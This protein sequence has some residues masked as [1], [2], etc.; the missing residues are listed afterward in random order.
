MENKKSLTSVLGSAFIAA[1]AALGADGNTGHMADY[2]QRGPLHSYFAG[3]SDERK[4]ELRGELEDI[5]ES[6]SA[7]YDQDLEGLGRRVSSEASMGLA[8]ANDVYAFVSNAP[9]ANITGLG[10]ALGAIK[11]VAELPALARYVRHSHDWYGAGLLLALKPVRYILPIIGPALE[12]GAFNRMVRRRIE[13]EAAS[14]FVSRIGKYQPL[15]QKV[16]Y[17]LS[18]PLD[19]V[20][21]PYQ[22]AA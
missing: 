6:K 9:L 18:A 12:A 3:V 1:R 2:L 17:A 13:H 7:K 8:V 4:T 10:Y 11:T 14:E 22:A 19:Q 20:S 16:S 15:A 21:E 5:L